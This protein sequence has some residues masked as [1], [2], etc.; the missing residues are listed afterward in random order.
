MLLLAASAQANTSR[1]RRTGP[2]PDFR[3]DKAVNPRGGGQPSPDAVGGPDGFGYIFF[4]QA[5]GCTFQFVDISATGTSIVTGDDS[6]SAPQALSLPFSF[7]GTSFN[8]LVMAS[9][10]YI[11][12]DLADTGPDLS[13]DC[14]L[15]ATPST[16]AGTTGMRI[17]PFHD[18]LNLT[19][20]ASAGF[21]QHFAACPRVQDTP[22]A[23][24]VFQWNDVE[25]FAD[26]G[27]TWDQE[28]ILYHTTGTIVNQIGPGNADAG[29]ASTTGIQ[30]DPTSG[31]SFTGLTYACNAAASVPANTAVCFGLPTGPDLVLTKTANDPNP[32]VG[33]PVTF[34]ITVQNT[35]PSVAQTGVEVVDNLPAGLTYASDTCAGDF[36]DGTWTIGNLAAGAQVSCDLTVTVTACGSF[37]NTATVSGDVLEAPGNNSDSVSL[38]GANQV[39]D[40]SFEASNPAAPPDTNPFWGETSTQFG[41]PICDTAFCGT[42]GGTAGPR[43]GSVW[44]WLGGATVGPEDGTVSQ[45]V[46]I[47]T[48]AFAALTFYLWN[49][50]GTTLT[51]FVEVTVDGNQEIQI[52]NGDP[53]YT[54]GY[55]PVT[56]DLAAYADGLAHNVVIRGF[57]G[58]TTTNFSVDDV[59]IVSCQQ[60]LITDL[61][62]TKVGQQ[63][64][65]GTAVYTITVLNN[66]PDDATGVVVTDTLPVELAYVS[67]TCGGANVPPW[68][69]NIGNLANG[70]QVSCD[71]TLDVLTPGAI[72]NTATVSG[73]DSDPTPANDSSTATNTFLG[74]GGVVLQEIPTL[75]AVGM[76][77]LL[78][79]LGGAA[80]LLLRRRGAV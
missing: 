18:D 23:C 8:S 36:A 17:Y 71:I 47:P 39:A 62:I 63:P 44:V 53:A 64:Q 77:A 58:A 14:P 80:V 24:T 22:Q 5:D 34:T 45:S 70:A 12:T 75:G 25:T 4:D 7:Y 1:A 46:T 54:G 38:G 65:A 74:G 73:N 33:A 40:P 68:T 67:D 56:V 49:G 57:Q 20:G 42:G 35:D 32:P 3:E 9:N 55:A 51:D 13:N 76:A 19:G 69:W 78:L 48:G 59:A 43:T 61:Q 16:P 21:V 52:F 15:P 26:P 72:N 6:A 10:G 41:S 66:G 37:T 2:P 50:S 60:A 31:A 30:S 79:L 28:T 27:V 29:A 11:T